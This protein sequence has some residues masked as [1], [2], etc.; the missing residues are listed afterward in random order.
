M[1]KKFKGQAPG[2]ALAKWLNHPDLNPNEV[3][4]LLMHAQVV[5]RWKEEHAG[6]H[7]K[8]KPPAFWDSFQKV[9]ET[10]AT[11]SYAQQLDVNELAD[12][13]G[14]RDAL[15]PNDKGVDLPLPEIRWLVQLM[16]HGAI[17][18]IRKCQQCAKWFFAHFSHQEF[19][20]YPCRRKHFEGTEDFK[21]KR[22]EYMRRRYHNLKKANV[23]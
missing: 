3:I 20:E 8:K 4:E 18:N 16:Q 5:Y 7:G 10:L 11:F 14:L 9:N 19:C 17:L 6:I 22:R 23:K 21:K 13:N 1:E 15:M 12:G 2:E